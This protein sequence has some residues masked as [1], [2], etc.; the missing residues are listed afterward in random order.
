MNIGLSAVNARLTICVIALFLPYILVIFTGERL[1]S[2]SAYFYTGIGPIFVG[3]LSLVCY[4][5]FTMPKWIPAA[6]LLFGVIMF[7]VNEWTLPHNICAVL[8][9]VASAAAIIFEKRE[10]WM[11]YSMLLIAPIALYDLFICE[12]LLVAVIS[13]YNIRKLLSIKKILNKKQKNQNPSI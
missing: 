1:D 3:V 4:L 12:V 13:T 7:P 6:I 5:M 11:G 9:F 8:F 10:S 2:F